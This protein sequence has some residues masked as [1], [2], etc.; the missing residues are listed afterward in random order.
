MTVPL[1]TGDRT[2]TV[3]S[4]WSV[5]DTRCRL[6]VTD[7]W[8]MHRARRVLEEQLTAV[9]RVVN[10]RRAGSVARRLRRDGSAVP[11]GVLLAE[12]LGRRPTVRTA[13]PA[14]F[15]YG[16][17]AVPDGVDV[18][19]PALEPWQLA[20]DAR[21]GLHLEP[22]P[23]PRAWTAQRCAE[24][25]AEATSCGVLVAVGG[26]VATSGLA[27]VGG[28]RVQL[29]DAPAGPATVVAVDGGAISQITTVR[30]G[31]GRSELHRVVVPATG[32]TVVPEWRSVAVAAADGPAASA[33]CRG[34]LLRG[35]GAAGWLA[36][37]GLPA[38]LVDRAG[39][40]HAVGRWPV[41]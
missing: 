31:R 4:E 16:L 11:V 38:R 23:S 37:L 1:H 6:V 25:V 28:W 36:D 41:D 10:P 32:R 33:A 39:E 18:H 8:A 13:E 19:H 17:A 27:P 12:L 15:P 30:V 2:V 3:C 34:A 35:T 40:V 7:P 21:D 20:L 24:L 29:R 22:G 14:P 26:D 5:W 9:D